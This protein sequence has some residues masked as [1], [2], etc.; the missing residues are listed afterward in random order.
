MPISSAHGEH[1]ARVAAWLLAATALD[2]LQN[3]ERAQ[4][5]ETTLNNV[6]QLL[7]TTRVN[8]FFGYERSDYS[9]AEGQAPVFLSSARERH[10]PE[11]RS[12]LDSALATHF[13]HQSREDALRAIGEV[14]KRLTY[15]EQF[16]PSSPDERSKVEHFFEAVKQQLRPAQ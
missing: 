8:P 10:V 1:D 13:E 4:E 12:A 5:A 6:Y 9:E 11:V 15:P 2:C 14:L 3:P 7:E 16:G